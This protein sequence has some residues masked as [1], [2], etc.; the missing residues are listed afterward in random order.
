MSEALD[1]RLHKR[2][3]RS[4]FFV[5]AGLI[6][7]VLTLFWNHPLAFLAFLCIGVPLTA[8]GVLLY[9]YAVVSTK[10]EVG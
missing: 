1:N 5:L 4:G 7:Q 2:L 6:V 10:E 3:L 9:L 8:A